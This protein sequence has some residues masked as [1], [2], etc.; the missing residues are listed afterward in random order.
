MQGSQLIFLISQPRSG[1]T[2]L[3]KLLGTHSEVYTR[4]EPWIMLHPA[5][6][7]KANGIEAQYDFGLWSKAQD[8]FIGGI[9]N[10]DELYIKEIRRMYLNLYSQYIKESGKKFFLDKTP[11][12]YL[13]IDELKQIFPKAKRILLIRNPLAVLGSIINT[14][15]KD[16]WNRLADFKYDLLDIIDIYIK[17]IESKD[18][19]VM[20]YE[21]LLEESDKTLRRIF[22]YI[23][24]GYEEVEASYYKQ[25]VNWMFG[26]TTNVHTKKGIDKTSD[27]KWINR[28]D[29]KQYWRVMSDYLEYIGK[30]RYEKLGYNFDKNKEI[31]HLAKRKFSQNKKYKVIKEI[32]T[33]QK[34][35]DSKDFFLK[36]IELEQELVNQKKAFRQ[37]KETMQSSIR[38]RELLIELQSEQIRDQIEEYNEV[39]K[40][41]YL[42]INSKRNKIVELSINLFKKP[43]S[44]IKFI[45]ELIKILFRK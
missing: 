16:D 37:Y 33:L 20:H 22:H 30:E 3:Q 2:L 7:L 1:S 13:I 15:I 39:K 6:A 9:K 27:N 12:Y 14:W 31:L 8:D 23:G 36:K 5:Y 28:L 44:L 41:N 29:D 42:V 19:F 43:F 11:R 21:D 45:P 34:L 17:N 26:D 32:K 38:K 35:L 24:I 25:K 18:I 4:S 40:L 10:G